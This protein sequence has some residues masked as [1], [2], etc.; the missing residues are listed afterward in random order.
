MVFAVFYGI[1]LIQVLL[2]EENAVIW[3]THVRIKGRASGPDTHSPENQY[4][5]ISYSKVAKDMHQ[6][7][8]IKHNH[9]S[10]PT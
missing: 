2:L 4:F 3:F 1:T 10:D 8:P 7:P 9:P 6:T 5:L